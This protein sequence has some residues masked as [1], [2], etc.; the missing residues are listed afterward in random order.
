MNTTNEQLQ[1]K[2]LY[3]ENEMKK[4]NYELI[5]VLNLN[6]SLLL[7]N[8]EKVIQN[9]KYAKLFSLC[10]GR[11]NRQARAAIVGVER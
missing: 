11:Y 10:E 2:K 5:E 4:L 8:K 3:L 6:D 7:E 1:E 9:R